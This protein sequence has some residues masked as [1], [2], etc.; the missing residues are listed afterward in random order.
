MLADNSQKCNNWADNFTKDWKKFGTYPLYNK[1]HRIS[2]ADYA[3]MTQETG[4]ATS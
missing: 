1:H 3:N 2:I 4:Q